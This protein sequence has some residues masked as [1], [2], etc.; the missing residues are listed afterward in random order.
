MNAI[1]SVIYQNWNDA[2]GNPAGGTA[3]GVGLSIHWQNG[4]L[5]RDMKRIEPNGAFVETVL[6]LCKKRLEFYETSKF[7]CDENRKAIEFI[8]DA[9][10]VL[11]WRTKKREERAVEG[12]HAV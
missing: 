1:D 9:L 2:N 11:D 10:T 6:A 5:G 4:P 7:S 8:E 12:T 3:E